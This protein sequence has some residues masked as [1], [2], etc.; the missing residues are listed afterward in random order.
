M[1]KFKHLTIVDFMAIRQVVDY[2]L[3]DPDVRLLLGRN[4]D[5]TAADDNGSGKSSFAEA[6][7]WVL[8][9]ETTRQAIDKSLT[10]E[11][12]IREGAKKAEVQ[13]QFFD[14]DNLYIV[15]RTRTA[16]SQ[17]IALELVPVVNG[18][19]AEQYKG[20]EAQLLVE[21]ALGIDVIQFSNLVLLDGAYPLLFAPS[22]DGTR[23]DILSDLVDMAVAAET[24]E[25]IGRKLVCASTDVTM[26]QASIANV[27]GNIDRSKEQMRRAKAEAKAEK[28]KANEFVAK[29]HAVQ[30]DMAE[31]SHTLDDAEDAL[32]GYKT[33]AVED[34]EAL[35]TAYDDAAAQADDTTKHKNKV[36]LH[37]KVTEIDEAR[38]ELNSSE[39]NHTLFTNQISKIE[40]LQ[41]QGMCPT[42]GQETQDVHGDD[43]AANRRELKEASDAIRRDQRSLEDL[44]AQRQKAIDAA[45]GNDAEAIN[46][47]DVAR[48]AVRSARAKTA[49]PQE[50]VDAVDDAATAHANLTALKNST[51]ARVKTC[52][53][54]IDRAKTE[55]ATAKDAIAFDSDMLSSY[56]K[57]LEGIVITRD[58]LE[59]WKKGFGSKGVPSLFI[60]TVLPRISARIQKYANVLTGGDL[61]VSLRAFK[62][63]KSKTVQESI[64]ISAVNSKGA[65]VYGA[66]STGERN[67]INLA[68]TLG[69]IEYFRDMNVFESNLLICDEIFD[70]LDRTGVQ[71]ALYALEE[72]DMDHVVV[73]SHHEQLKPLFP[74]VMFMTKENGEA[75]LE[76]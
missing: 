64:Q 16:S 54:L 11:H 51:V 32:E 34:L 71:Q 14:D 18:G 74:S 50:L 73:I 76:V 29:A 61:T 30:A 39:H 23:K 27:E 6:I 25:F 55:Y 24:Q 9:G 56:T 62:E 66:N 17:K 59:F 47:R 8:Y 7:K 31:M 72:A 44:E 65:S 28:T 40:K 20:K 19:S 46:K 70:G 22:S 57:E 75:T 48:T 53:A 4:L 37:Y 67:R 3:S 58:N 63:T 12:V 42:C 60:E 45:T 41:A 69:L 5:S 2:D 33:D 26:K 36:V 10:V 38:G 52:K 1:I 15:T 21:D 68:V 49:P 35:E 13:I 43:L